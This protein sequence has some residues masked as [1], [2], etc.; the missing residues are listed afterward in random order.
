MAL[1]AHLARRRESMHQLLP[2][3]SR[4]P[5]SAFVPRGYEPMADALV[6]GGDV[7]ACAIEVGRDLATDGTALSQVVDD[8]ELMY[9]AVEAGVPPFRVVRALCLAWN[10]VSLQYLHGLSCEDPLTG[11]ASLPHLR[12]RLDELQR[13]AERCG[14]YLSS[15]YALVVVELGAAL[16]AP[17]RQA[18]AG[19]TAASVSARFSTVLR[20]VEVAEAMRTVFSGGETL[21]RVGGH[22]AVA[23]VPR[24][25]ALGASVEA[26]RQ[27]LTDWSVEPGVRRTPRVWIESLPTEHQLTATLLDELV[28]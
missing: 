3:Q 26:L 5:R 20:M 13:A 2:V 12:S 1:F 7:E 10:E 24:D 21:A 27:L 11:L 14:E 18:A 23:L 9:L 4:A 17:P 28:R 22:R 6:Y 15:G 8:L 25:A 19:S 16:A